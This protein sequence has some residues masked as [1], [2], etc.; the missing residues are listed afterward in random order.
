[1]A[2]VDAAIDPGG[3]KRPPLART[4]CGERMTLVTRGK[5]VKIDECGMDRILIFLRGSA[6][7]YSE[8]DVL[9]ADVNT[10]VSFARALSPH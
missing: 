8:A 2:A 7:L 9:C 1:M 10:S 6:A 5:T 4:A 3:A